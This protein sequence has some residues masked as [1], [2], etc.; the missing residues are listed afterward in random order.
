MHGRREKNG[1]TSAGSVPWAFAR[2]IEAAASREIRPCAVPPPRI[3]GIF[4]QKS[5]SVRAPEPALFLDVT[6]PDCLPV[7]SKP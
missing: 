2:I 6:V 3:R 5:G 1:P 7:P 4:G